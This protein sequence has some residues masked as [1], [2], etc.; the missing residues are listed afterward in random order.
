[1]LALPVRRSIC[2][3]WY[4]VLLVSAH[5]ALLDTTHGENCSRSRLSHR[6]I[7]LCHWSAGIARAAPTPCSMPQHHLSPSSSPP[8]LPQRRTVPRPHLRP[9]ASAALQGSVGRV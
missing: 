1:M 7:R 5:K 3:S 2:V 9:L 4:V 6:A 8:L